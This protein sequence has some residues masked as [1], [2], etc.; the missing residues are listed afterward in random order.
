[1]KSPYIYTILAIVVV[2]AIVVWLSNSSTTAEAGEL[3]EFAQ[4]LEEEGATF[5]G[6]FWCPHC[7][8]QKALFGKSVRH[9][10]Y[11]ECST[12]DRRSQLSVCREN[13]IESY[14]TWEFADGS[15]EGGVLSLETLSV[16]TGCQLPE[17]GGNS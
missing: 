1:M 5:F 3:D 13:N 6:A 12:P 16:K 9:L 17:V 2:L 11:V 14:P 4:C 10:P 7:Q 15:R 8:E